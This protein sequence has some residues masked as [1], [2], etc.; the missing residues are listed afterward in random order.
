MSFQ[1][2]RSILARSPWPTNPRLPTWED[3]KKGGL[4]RDENLIDAIA[5]ALMVA[6]V[7]LVAPPNWGK[8]FLCYSVAH[9]VSTLASPRTVY[10]KYAQGDWLGVGEAIDDVAANVARA[11]KNYPKPE[12]ITYLYVVD[13]CHLADELTE[14]LVE[15]VD[16]PSVALL[17]ATRGD[18]LDD[19][20]QWA[21]QLQDEHPENVFF[22]GSR[23]GLAADVAS[24]YLERVSQPALP[25][26]ELEAYVESIGR[27]LSR[28]VLGLDVWWR[29]GAS[30]N[31]LSV[32]DDK[33]LEFTRHEFD[34]DTLNRPRCR[35]LQLLAVYGQHEISP[36]E[37]IFGAELKEA[38]QNLIDDGLAMR[39]ARVVPQCCLRD[40][41]TCDWVVRALDKFCPRGVLRSPTEV[42][43][44]H[45]TIEPA[46]T[47][48]WLRAAALAGDREYVQAI[49]GNDEL[50]TKARNALERR[51]SKTLL[52]VLYA[53]LC[54]LPENEWPLLRDLVPPAAVDA[55]SAGLR[56]AGA[57]RI[58]RGLKILRW[59]VNLG[60]MFETWAPADWESMVEASSTNTLRLLCFDLRFWQLKRPIRAIA[61]ALT[62]AD[63]TRILSIEPG[64]SD[65][66]TVNGLIGNLLQDAPDDAAA[67][68]G[69]LAFAD[70]DT[71]TKTSIGKDL[72]WLLSQVLLLNRPEVA[73]QFVQRHATSLT[74]AFQAEGM[75][76]RFWLLWNI[77]LANNA[78]AKGLPDCDVALFDAG[79][80]KFAMTLAAH[81]LLTISGHTPTSPF[82]IPSLSIAAEAIRLATSPTIKV[83]AAGAICRHRTGHEVATMAKHV[84][85]AAVHLVMETFPMVA[86]RRV[87]NRVLDR[88]DICVRRGGH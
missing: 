71:L 22:L 77:Y 53:T 60:E 73:S 80:G 63:L 66:S 61:R 39:L 26:A 21:W 40:T 18:S 51:T 56:G 78:V 52:K 17:L 48:M 5:A 88:I 54:A 68:V 9:H 34:I 76:H 42:V 82:E 1:E 72:S 6:P 57:Y 20:P 47:Y 4:P 59:F 83:L 23:P 67:V 75:P 12:Q 55:L 33:L 14:T 32:S 29:T 81:E 25:K 49:V 35:A 43:Q 50:R 30:G 85:I 13:D 79:D 10:V 3:L 19:L 69:R 16:P 36:P 64:N 65:L 86:G 84:D 8:T 28:L 44:L 2:I 27:D 7:C 45:A 11:R 15:H 38:L 58:R 87:L 24:T 31:P 37:A 62:K 74:S 41:K 46:A 70:L